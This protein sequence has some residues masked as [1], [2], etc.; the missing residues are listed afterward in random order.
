[1]ATD[2]FQMV[3]DSTAYDAVRPK[4]IANVTHTRAAHR[5]LRQSSSSV[6]VRSCSALKSTHNGSLSGMSPSVPRW[7]GGDW[8][9]LCCFRLV[10]YGI[11]ALILP[12]RTCW[13]FLFCAVLMLFWLGD[14][15]AKYEWGIAGL[16]L[17]RG[18]DRDSLLAL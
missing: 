13:L 11:A 18:C 9:T 4:Q 7:C 10:R 8:W 16:S 12:Q 1:M 14:V 5:L 2:A 6:V 15:A 17:Y 3:V